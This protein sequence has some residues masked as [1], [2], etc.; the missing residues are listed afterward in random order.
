MIRKGIIQTIA[1][2]ITAAL[3]VAAPIYSI[4][5]YAGPSDELGV[6]IPHIGPGDAEEY[7][8]QLAG[9]AAAAAQNVGSQVNKAV[10]PAL[11]SAD[12]YYD[13]PNANP[14]A[15]A[16]DMYSYDMMVHDLN[17]MK[18]A[19]PSLVKVNSI[20]TSLDGRT[21]YDVIVGN[22]NAQ[23]KILVQ[24][25]IHGR[26]YIVSTITMQ[27]IDALLNGA[28]N[29]GTFNGKPVS[30][31]LQQVCF[32]FV[33][34]ANPDG[35]SIS[36]LGEAGVK[37]PKYR[38]IMQNGFAM[39]TATGRAGA[40][41]YAAYL[42]HWKSNAAGVD[43]NH[44]FD[45]NWQEIVDAG[46]GR[47]VGYKGSAPLSEPESKALANLANSN[48]FSATI[49]YHSM[50]NILY[51][52]AFNNNAAQTSFEIASLVHDISGF[53]ILGNLGHGGFKD[54][55]QK[56]STIPSLTVE[57]GGSECPV[58]FAEYPVIWQNT[59]AIPGIIAEYV[60]NH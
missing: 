53:G 31:M 27:Q 10:A 41:D 37:N 43:L 39:D 2:I 9:M 48:R 5:T 8:Q 28:A 36:Q 3:I 24:A 7:A 33:P 44:N 35:I 14:Q 60:L 58:N 40:A 13:M 25:G 50:G 54:W 46:Y 12:N 20:G 38:E 55:I 29:G 57:M 16:I 42:R 21:I 52:D 4:V 59:K 19:Y 45:A 1:G 51:W 23:K 56:V 49:S 26:E 47:A 6:E 34:M 17:K 22:P 30:E 18:Q 32:H 15:A 11:L